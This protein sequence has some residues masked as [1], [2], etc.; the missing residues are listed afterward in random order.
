MDDS[1]FPVFSDGDVRVWIGLK[2]YQLHSGVLEHHS[3]YFRYALRE[4]P[5]F[6]GFAHFHVVPSQLTEVGALTL[7]ESVSSPLAFESQFDDPAKVR[8]YW[9]NILRALYK[10][11][12][13]L[14]LPGRQL[15][16]VAS[17]L[18]NLGDF[19]GSKAIVDEGI[20][21]ALQDLGQGLFLLIVSDP[22]SWLYFGS[23]IRSKT[24]YREAVVHLVGRLPGLTPE[25]LERLVF[26]PQYTRD[27]LLDSYRTVCDAKKA[28]EA[29]LWGYG[30]DLNDGPDSPMMKAVGL[31]RQWIAQHKALGNNIVSWDGGARLYRTIASGG[32][33]YL[34]GDQFRYV[35]SPSVGELEAREILDRLAQVKDD[36]KQFVAPL[37]VNESRFDPQRFGQ[38]PYLTCAKIDDDALPWNEWA[39]ED[40]N[41]SDTG[42]LGSEAGSD[43][44]WISW[45]DL[46]S[47]DDAMA[48]ES[49]E[50]VERFHHL[51]QAK[52]VSNSVEP[53]EA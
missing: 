21:L 10:I 41:N 43:D 17:G 51:R 18:A 48:D 19:I 31:F 45:A 15:T 24:I 27:L 44:S 47:S 7:Q 14:H 2:V 37:L 3:R 38:L 9:E 30:S 34:P 32:Q 39:I 35:Y 50:K 22:I 5:R 49:S 28:A 46:E 52:V 11:K 8:A 16:A 36:V 6:E 53:D 33:A 4:A 29:L 40:G 25:D 1:N 13:N 26:L 20:D 12:P 42:L 23:R